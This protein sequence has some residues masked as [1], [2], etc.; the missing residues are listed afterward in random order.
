MQG[1]GDILQSKVRNSPLWRGV[2]ANLVVDSANAVIAEIFGSEIAKYTKAVYV[3]K[4][5]LTLA[6]LS[7][8]AAQEIRLHE[9]EIIGKI[10]QK[11]RAGSV[12]KI[13]YLD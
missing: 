4:G 5:V 7:S 12:E 10:N 9:S 8:V 11:V 1:L 2:E 13:K 6:C 3:K